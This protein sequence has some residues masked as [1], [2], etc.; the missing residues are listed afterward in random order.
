MTSPRPAIPPSPRRISVTL[1]YSLH[2]TLV[3][4]SDYEGRSLSNL[5]SYLLE[6]VL[7]SKPIS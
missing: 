1:P 3:D 5:A 4:R 6:A 2:Q 7:K